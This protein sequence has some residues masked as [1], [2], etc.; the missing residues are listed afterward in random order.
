MKKE[1]TV[2]NMPFFIFPQHGL[3]LRRRY[4][5]EISFCRKL[6]LADEYFVESCCSGFFKKQKPSFSDGLLYPLR[7]RITF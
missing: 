6:K 7:H 5:S 1:E 4:V 2:C 3:R